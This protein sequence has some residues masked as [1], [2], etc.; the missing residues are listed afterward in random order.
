MQ[1]QFKQIISMHA[2]NMT[3]AVFASLVLSSNEVLASENTNAQELEAKLA[4]EVSNGLAESLAELERV[5]NINSGTMNF[6]G[7]VNV[8]EIFQTQLTE[9]GFD[10]RWIDGK[11]FDRAGHLLATRIGKR[12]GKNDSATKILLI[13]HLDTVFA[14]DDEFQSFKR[15]GNGSIAGP[16][17]IDMKGGNVIIVSALR[18]LA[19]VDLLEDL[20]LKVIMTGDE[21]RSGKPL[22]ESKK[23]LIEAAEWADIALG[24]EDGDGNIKTAVI[25]RRGSVDW[26][27]QVTGMPAHSS[28]IFQ[29]DVGYGA[30]FETARI[31]NAFREHLAGFGELT[32]N[33]GMIIGGSNLEYDKATASGTAFG[34]NNVIAKSA[35]VTGGIRALTTKELEKAQK[36]MQDIAADNLPHTSATLSFGDGYPPMAPSDGNKRLL[37]MYSDISESLGYGEIDAVDPRNAGAADISFTAGLVDMAL[38]G[39]GLMGSGGHTKDEIADISSLEKN[40]QKAA[41]LLYRLKLIPE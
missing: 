30:V 21:E 35:K 13:G 36:V 8:G 28:Q 39:L 16:G 3:I 23:A 1:N 11:S 9:L 38:D 26:E 41:I 33:P 17:I 7:V 40:T 31:L 32:F 20:S 37:E 10:T 2:L 18:A 27:L 15:L 22:S 14:K 19:R 4:D 12:S 6:Q 25:A 34:K 24:F 5:V 29:P